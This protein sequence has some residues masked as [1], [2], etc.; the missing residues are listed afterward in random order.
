MGK[1][2]SIENRVDRVL[3]DTLVHGHMDDLRS[4]RGFSFDP[5]PARFDLDLDLSAIAA[6][7]L[8]R[9]GS[10]GSAPWSRF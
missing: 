1:T 10:L 6:S 9:S 5:H 2:G 4:P 8:D 3:L 7:G